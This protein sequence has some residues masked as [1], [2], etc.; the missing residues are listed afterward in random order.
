MVY[1][2]IFK[3][4]RFSVS[5]R[6]FKISGMSQRQSD[7]SF[8]L[9]RKRAPQNRLKNTTLRATQIAKANSKVTFL[10]QPATITRPTDDR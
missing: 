6:L 8:S 2:L 7:G 9:E 3:K 4:P 1:L 10:N 5:G